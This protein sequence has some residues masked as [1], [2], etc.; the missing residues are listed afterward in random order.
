MK[1]NAHYQACQET[2][3]NDQMPRGGGEDALKR[4]EI[5]YK[6]GTLNEYD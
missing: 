4:K 5:L 2:G 1:F 6:T 3:P